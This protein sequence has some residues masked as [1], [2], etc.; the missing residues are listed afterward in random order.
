MMPIEELESS[1]NELPPMFLKG[2]KHPD[3]LRFVDHRGFFKVI[4]EDN[5][6]WG[7]LLCK[8]QYPEST[9]EEEVRLQL[10]TKEDRE[11][12]DRWDVGVFVEKETEDFNDD[13]F[14]F[15]E[16]SLYVSAFQKAKELSKEA[17]RLRRYN[18]RR[19]KEHQE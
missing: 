18:L 1:I 6:Y 15:T 19:K 16:E 11:Y 8:E 5:K 4:K 7:Y 13:I 17:R 14:L 10:F 12:S 9:I 3:E 2:F